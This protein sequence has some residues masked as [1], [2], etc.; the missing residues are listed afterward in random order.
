MNLNQLR[1]KI[2]SNSKNEN[3]DIKKVLIWLKKRVKED[4]TKVKKITINDL[5][6]WNV[7]SNGNIFHKSNQFFSLQGIQTENATNREIKKWDQ[8][9]LF[10][11]HGGILAILVREK[12]SKIEFLLNARREPGDGKGELKLCPSF[13][14]TQSNMNL[15]HGGKRTELSELIINSKNV[16]G[17]TLH[18][19]E[20]ARFWKKPNKN[21]LIF[22]EKKNYKKIKNKNFIW[23]NLAQIK[24]LNLI[25]GIINPFVKTILFMI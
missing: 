10:Q 15:A 21:L 3:Y 8:P 6:D 16:I 4:K 2:I 18:Y 24:K 14:A 1:K 23:L 19:E 13:S 25:N 12:N 7:H 9:I 5:K 17:K 11:K 20:G 22:L